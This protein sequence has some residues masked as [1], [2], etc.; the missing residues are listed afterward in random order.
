MVLACRTNEQIL[1]RVE[2]EATVVTYRR[3]NLSTA[4]HGTT[5]VRHLVRCGM[6]VVRPHYYTLHVSYN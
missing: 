2:P 5:C 4:S 1:H 6:P 3:V